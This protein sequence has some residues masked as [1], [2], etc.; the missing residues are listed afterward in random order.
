MT[1]EGLERVVREL[2]RGHG[3]LDLPLHQFVYAAERWQQMTDP[4]VVSARPYLRYV[5]ARLPD[6][7]ASHLE[8][9]GLVLP[10]RHPFWSIWYPPNGLNCFCTVQSVSKSLLDRR[11]WTVSAAP[12]FEYPLPDD[13]FDFNIGQLIAASSTK[14]E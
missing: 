3:L 2:L 5:C 6:S 7:R 11:R 8:K 4:D 13:G 10:V 1:D 9:H 12:V 14:E